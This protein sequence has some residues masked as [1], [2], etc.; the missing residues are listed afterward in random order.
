ME[1]L[2]VFTDPS[3]IEEYVLS[4][5]LK[6][7]GSGW[8]GTV[9]LASNNNTLKLFRYNYKVP[10]TLNK[11]TT[12]DLSLKSFIFPDQLFICDGLIYGYKAKYFSNDI[13]N[14]KK[15][16]DTKIDVLNLLNARR[17][18]IKDIEVLTNLNYKLID[19]FGNVLFDG[20]NLAFIDTLNYCIR[21][22]N[23][24]ENIK[25][26]DDVL[27]Y[28]LKY[29]DSTISALNIPFEEKVERILKK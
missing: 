16:K 15:T 18:A 1:H 23:L 29:V 4:N 2:R 27:N 7:I 5:S 20:E 9:Y 8:E 25:A 3:E 21:K 19:V 26:L 10:Y 11:I 12:H 28:Q 22:T 6:E 13:F 14:I 17:Q 24:D